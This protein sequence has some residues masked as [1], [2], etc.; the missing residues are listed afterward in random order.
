MKT[1]ILAFT[2]IVPLLTAAQWN[3]LNPQLQGDP[4]ND[5]VFVSANDGFAITGGGALMKTTDAGTTWTMEGCIAQ[6]YLTDLHFSD[7]THGFACGYMGTFVRTTDGGATWNV[8]NTTFNSDDFSGIWFLNNTTGFMIADYGV[9]IKTTNGGDTWTAVSTGSTETFTDIYFPSA[10]TGYVSTEDGYFMKTT[11]GGAT[12]TELDT[13]QA[14]TFKCVWFTDENTGWMAGNW[15]AIYKTTN[16]G[17]SWTSQSVATHDYFNAICFVDASTGYLCADGTVFK[18][19]NGGTT[20]TQCY[21]P[22]Y[23]YLYSIYADAS[24]RVFAG[25]ERGRLYRS[26]DAGNTWADLTTDRMTPSVRLNAVAFFNDQ[27]GIVAGSNG[28]LFRTENAGLAWDSIPAGTFQEIYDF[29]LVSNTEA[30][31][32]AGAGTILH[33]SD[34]GET[35]TSIVS[36]TTNTLYGIKKINASFAVA[37]GWAGTVLTSADGGSTWAS[38]STGFT[39]GLYDIDFYNGSTGIC[40]GQSGKIYRS[41]DGGQ[42]WTSVTSGSSQYLNAVCFIDSLNVVVGTNTQGFLHS[43]DGGLTWS[44]PVTNLEM[45]VTHLYCPSVDTVFACGMEGLMAYSTDRGLNWTDMDH[46]TYWLLNDMSKTPSG[47]MYAVG[48]NSVILFRGEM[49]SVGFENLVEKADLSLHV[50]PNPAADCIYIENGHQQWYMIFDEQGR[51]IQSGYAS[52]NSIDIRSL[53]PGNYFIQCS[54]SES[55][56]TGRFIKK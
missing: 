19:T 7:A 3:W 15:G 30:Y 4:I 23:D 37:C 26:V 27:T 51:M 16:G 52:E 43:S 40:V 56:Q 55:V 17:T 13:Y 25:N 10:T 35:W 11:D 32:S 36:G 5:I 28:V 45:G 42:T 54:S 48:Y 53:A 41:T 20:W 31:A 22:N 6:G 44:V 39:T 24:G 9:M 2:L 8:I 47:N 21:N 29:E 34:A 18:T 33:T 14:E 1:I 49:Q 50:Y 38:I 12:W 46:T